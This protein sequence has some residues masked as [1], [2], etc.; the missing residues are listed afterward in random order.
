LSNLALY[1]KYRSQDF[2]EVVGQGHIVDTLK[3]SIKNGKPSHAYLLTGPRG[4]GKTTIARLIAKSINKL[5]KDT[6]LSDHLDIIEIDGASNRGIDEIRNLKEKIQVSPAKLEYKVYIIDEVHMLTKEAFNALL[7]TLEE[8]P[9]HAVFIFATTEIHKVPDTIISRTQRFDFK[10]ISRSDII[11]H[12]EY[13][14][15]QEKIDIDGPALGLIAE[16][17]RGGF[18]DAISLLDQAAGSGGKVTTQQITELTGLQDPSKI[19]DLIS[20]AITHKSAEVIAGLNAIYQEGADPSILT[21]QM[22]ASIAS[23]IADQSTHPATELIRLSEDLCWVQ[24]N[25]RFTTS[26][27]LVLQVGLLRSVLGDH[28]NQEVPSEKGDKS[29]QQ[30][31]AVA[32]P[33]NNTKVKT[34]PSRPANA[35]TQDNSDDEKLIK[36]LSVI[37]HYNNSLYALLRGA[38]LSVTDAGVYVK[39]RFS[40]HRD[41]ITEPR[42]RQLIEKAFSKVYDRPMSLNVSV[43]SSKAPSSA[44]TD[45]ELISSAIAILGGEVVDG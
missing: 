17:S 25:L 37:K 9:E 13:I 33:S 32:D 41:R 24:S 21:Q 34:Q 42:N 3:T 38:D 18:R 35:P 29:S 19:E 40:F 11:N 44:D 23:M 20:L 6:V 31:K 4:V 27:G 16:I 8:P 2:D 15:R 12:L 7:K 28:K 26:P 1:R 36:S 30:P 14:A 5:P 39:C 43:E 22:L 45:Q 10:P